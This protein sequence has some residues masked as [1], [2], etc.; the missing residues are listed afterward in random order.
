M[1]THNLDPV[2][3]DLGIIA[4]KWYSIAYILGILAGWWLG[5]KIIYQKINSGAN[6]IEN[7]DFDN[8]I[9]YIIFSIIIGGR[10]GFVIFYN[11]N[12]YI[13]N[14]IEIFMIWKG[15]MSFHGGL[16]GIII[17]TLLFSKK[18]KIKIFNLFDVVACVAPIGIFFGRI[19]NFINSELYGKPT[20][21]FW[22][23]VFPKIDNLNRHPSQIYEALLEGLVLFLV[24]N[25]IIFK[26]NYKEG[27]C[28]YI[29]LILY[30]IF[31]IFS[32]QFRVS[33]YSTIYFIGKFSTGSILSIVMLL[34][35]MIIFYKKFYNL[36]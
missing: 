10:L 1:Y 23:V 9:T 29:F 36:K 3:I 21:I 33:D 27:Q 22:S 18:K 30:S 20:E 19:A 16:L 24:L 11:L 14:P 2:L 5:K 8:Y 31:R 26:K 17:G 13:I 15:G 6:K 28:S 7:E 32:E 25:Y 12:Y 4:I 34:A 35:G